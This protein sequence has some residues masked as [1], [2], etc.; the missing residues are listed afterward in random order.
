ML[1]SGLEE[2]VSPSPW[3]II[4]WIHPLEKLEEKKSGYAYGNE[5]IYNTVY[6]IKK[7]MECTC[8]NFTSLISEEIRKLVLRKLIR[9]IYVHV[10]IQTF[11][12]KMAQFE[13]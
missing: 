10:Y 2:S 1:R 6:S 3:K 4:P 7:N 5:C 9:F 11:K 8:F 13:E 12:M